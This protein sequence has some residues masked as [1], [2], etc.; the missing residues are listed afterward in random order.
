MDASTCAITGTIGDT[1]GLT[2][3][4]ADKKTL[5]LNADNTV[6]WTAGDGRTLTVNCDN[7]YGLPCDELSVSWDVFNGVC[8]ASSTGSD[9]LNP[10]TVSEPLA[11]I[12]D[13]I[14]QSDTLYITG[15][16]LSAA[17]VLVAQ[18]SY[19]LDWAGDTNRIS[20]QE[21]ISLY[22]GYDTGDWKTRN[23]NNCIISDSSD[24]DGTDTNPNCAVYLGTGI[25]D[26]TVLDGFTIEGSDYL[27][28]PAVFCENSSPVIRNCRILGGGNYAT[29]CPIGIYI[30]TTGTPTAHPT[31]EN[32]YIDARGGGNVDYCGF[33]I[34]MI[35]SSPIITNNTISGGETDFDLSGT[36]SWPTTPLNAA[37]SYG[38]YISRSSAQEIII[39]TT[40]LYADNNIFIHRDINSNDNR[41]FGIRDNASGGHIDSMHNNDFYC[42]D[43]AFNNV[44]SASNSH[45]WCFYG[46]NLSPELYQDLGTLD[47]TEAWTAGNI[48]VHPVFEN[49]TYG[50]ED[51]HLTSSSPTSV[52]RGGLDGSSWDFDLDLDGADRT[53]DWSMGAYEYDE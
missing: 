4:S 9:S 40:D 11:T 35:E 24:S 3:W 6:A 1:T 19:P 18:G 36:L 2:S 8:V 29:A 25:T 32:K 28:T 34:Y 41:I 23:R 26:A 12:D 30:N 10:G 20:M 52:T 21:G 7:T 47:A 38:I 17:S 14:D 33:G 31:I 13:G 16:G 15:K 22:G 49:E 53:A 51:L 27:Y 44:F 45:E 5:T 39:T 43:A 42:I 37:G 50:S 46:T 48:S